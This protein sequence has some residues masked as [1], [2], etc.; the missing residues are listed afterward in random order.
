[1]PSRPRDESPHGLAKS[2]ESF[3]LG[4]FTVVT[5]LLRVKRGASAFALADPRVDVLAIQVGGEEWPGGRQ[6]QPEF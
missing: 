3:R 1:M 4:S 5:S 6:A 2:L